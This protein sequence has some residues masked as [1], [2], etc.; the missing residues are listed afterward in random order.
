M[1]SSSHA[2]VFIPDMYLILMVLLL[3]LLARYETCAMSLGEL[4]G[5]IKQ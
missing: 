2:S 1:R 5:A 3:K 4:N